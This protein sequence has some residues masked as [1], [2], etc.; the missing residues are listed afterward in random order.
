MKSKPK[1]KY[2]RDN[3]MKNCPLIPDMA[4][5]E[6][7]M[8]SRLGVKA[9]DTFKAAKLVDPTIGAVDPI[10]T[11]AKLVDSLMVAKVINST[12]DVVDPTTV[13]TKLVDSF[14]EKEVVDTWVVMVNAMV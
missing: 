10:E 7:M 13:K 4:R 9:V 12:N 3:K 8:A 14:I 1:V 2:N 5:G 6:T 11:K